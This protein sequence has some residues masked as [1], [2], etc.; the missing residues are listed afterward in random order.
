MNIRILIVSIFFLMSAFKPVKAQNFPYLN[1]STGNK[2]DFIVDADSNIIMFHGSKVEKLDKHFNLIWANSYSD[3]KIKN[4][5]LSKTG[6]LFYISYSYSGSQY[7]DRVGKIET[8]GSLSWSKELPTY[9]TV[10]SGNTQTVSINN[11]DQLFLDRNNNLIVTGGTYPTGN[12]MYLLKLDTLGTPLDLRLFENEFFFDYK[13]A[14]I[15]NDNSGVYTISAWGTSSGDPVFNLV[16]KYSD[17]THSIITSSICWVDYR[18]PINDTPISNEHIFK[19]KTD[20]NTFYHA[21]N[22]GFASNAL[23]NTF[24]LKKF[25]D[26]VFVWEVLFTT[27][28]P[29]V[30]NLQDLEEDHRNNTFL[31]ISTENI[32]TDKIDKWI[33][34]V[35]SNGTSDDIKHNFMQ[36]F[37]SSTFGVHDSIT[38]LKHHYGNNYFYSIQSSTS[39]SSP[40]SIIKMDSTIGSYCSP[41]PFKNVVTNLVL[42]PVANSQST[43]TAITSFSVLPKTSI[44]TNL[45]NYSITISSCLPL[46][47]KDNDISSLLLVYPSPANNKISVNT[48]DNYNI[49][50]LSVF[51]VSGKQVILVTH[52]T[53]I[54]V[55]ELNSGIY[56]IKIKTDQGEFIRKF[57]KE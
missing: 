28:S 7:I 4:L 47:V 54:D 43:V 52:Q 37:S 35:N 12:N 13:I 5:L 41:S 29:Y 36:N 16:L 39:L 48:F 40:L 21:Y 19:S 31:S 46:N 53:Y 44:V 45:T 27:A 6:S 42:P 22:K 26:T 2:T 3:L 50:Q 24:S 18:G 11:A 30:M 20:P 17:I 56:F 15:I 49:D 8:D 57:I 1:A 38:Q 33:V 9:T 14:S 25:R 23:N 55:S 51:D 34:K 10:V 32:S